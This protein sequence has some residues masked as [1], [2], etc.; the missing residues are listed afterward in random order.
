MTELVFYSKKVTYW[1]NIS[2]FFSSQNYT[3]Y[4]T[5]FHFI[6]P[7]TVILKN[8]RNF[9]GV[10]RYKVRQQNYVL[11][12]W[13]NEKLMAPSILRLQ[14]HYEDTVYFFTSSRYSID[15]PRKDERLSCSSSHPVVLN[16]GPL[17]WECSTLTTRSLLHE[18][19]TFKKLNMSDCVGFWQ[20]SVVTEMQYMLIYF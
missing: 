19:R 17:D 7:V 4:S 18:L 13:W 2:S 1:S 6:L 16:P 5:L 14:S 3:D 9:T 20:L 10:C 12:P 8:V 11:Y 15:W